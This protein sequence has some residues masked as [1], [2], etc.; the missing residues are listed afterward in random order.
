VSN[1]ATTSVALEWD[2]LLAASSADLNSAD[3]AESDLHRIRGLLEQPVEWEAVLRLAD[4][5]GTSSLL[6]QNLSRFGDMVPS[7]VLETLR[8]LYEKNVYKSLFLTN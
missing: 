4:D 2:L 7:P 3:A 1:A 6:Y 5:H 8:Q